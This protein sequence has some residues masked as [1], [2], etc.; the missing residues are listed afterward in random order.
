MKKTILILGS[1][2]LMMHTTLTGS[3]NQ[4]NIIIIDYFNSIDHGNFEDIGKLLSDD[5]TA[6]LPVSEL[7]LN[8]NEVIELYRN[9]KNQYP[10]LNHEI[11][12]QY[13]DEHMIL[14]RGIL[15][16]SNTTSANQ[17]ILYRNDLLL[18]FTSLFEISNTGKIKSLN[19]QF[20]NESLESQMKSH[21]PNT[22]KAGEDLVSQLFL[23]T[24]QGKTD[25]LTT[26]CN[27]DFK[28]TAPYFE[29]IASLS[30][31][32]KFLEQQKNSFQDRHT[33]ITEISSEG[34][35]ITTKAIFMGTNTGSILGLPATGNRVE[36]P[37]TVQD[38]LDV[39]GKL[40]HR[41]IQFNIQILERQIMKDINA[42]DTM[43]RIFKIMEINSLVNKM[44]AMI[45]AIQE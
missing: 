31:Y 43:K 8:K 39:N 9:Y 18:H 1:L 26:A 14:I 3:A 23:A 24:D 12:D 33:E 41:T 13:E 44:T 34:T 17:N 35:R 22:N 15:K 6:W 40:L 11:I 32:Q 30:D 2:F 19:M 42:T 16:G 7:S 10:L 38:E 37:F 36:L 27:A 29:T 45:N 5:F 21:Q 25:Q 20:D 4:N 28:I